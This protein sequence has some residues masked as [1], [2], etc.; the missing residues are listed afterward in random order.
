[1]FRKN[2]EIKYKN[3]AQLSNDWKKVDAIVEKQQNEYEYNQILAQALLDAFKKNDI[4]S[5]VSLQN[6]GANINF[7]IDDKTILDYCMED[8]NLKYAN[9][10]L[11]L[12]YNINKRNS[13]DFDILDN[14]LMEK[15]DDFVKLA[16]DSGITITKVFRNRLTTRLIIAT[17]ASNVYGVKKLLS[18]KDINVNERDAQGNTALHYNLQKEQTPDDAIITRLLLKQG[19]DIDIMNNKGQKANDNVVEESVLA[20]IE[21]NTLVQEIKEDVKVNVS[22]KKRKL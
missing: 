8:D 17:K 22:I 19:G 14:A 1:M 20:L 2:K 11:A 6:K 15:N 18:Y 21:E 16:I 12:G 10:A 9:L 13:I 7:L 3:T 4:E 5:I